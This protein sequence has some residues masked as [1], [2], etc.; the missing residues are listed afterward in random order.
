M[1]IS[2]IQYLK[3]SDNQNV[4]EDKISDFLGNVIPIVKI[5]KKKI[6]YNNGTYIGPISNNKPNGFGKFTTNKNHRFYREYGTHF[7][8]DGEWIEGSKEGKFILNV[9]GK[10]YTGQCEN[11]S[12][13]VTF[14]SDTIYLNIIDG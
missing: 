6:D 4:I 13:F 9:D 2:D 1:G 8:I 3:S 5:T 11:D 10:T 12:G 7:S 14:E